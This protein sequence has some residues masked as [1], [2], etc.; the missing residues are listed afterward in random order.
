M[1]EPLR[2]GFAG[3]RDIS[4]HVLNYLIDC[5][6]VPSVLILSEPGTATSA[7]E[8]VEAARRDG[9]VPALLTADDIRGPGAA[10]KIAGY[11]LDY[12][13]CVHFPY[14]LSPRVLS[15]LR[16]GA[17]NLHPAYLPFN[18]GWHTPSWSIYDG[19]PAGATLHFMSDRTDAGD[20]IYQEQ[21][22]VEPFDTAHT[23]YQ[24]LKQKELAV[25]KKGWTDLKAGTAA[26]VPQD[27]SR[28]TTHLK[29][30]LFQEK[31]QRLDLGAEV[32]A[33][34]L[35]KRLR[36]MTTNRQDEAAY[37]ELAGRRYRVQVVINPDAD[38]V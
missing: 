2:L 17:L 19:T 7:G 28:A 27:E 20:I 1:H 21:V 35:L 32:V 33:G 24:K 37:F 36:A 23:L 18:R 26:R 4:V 3:D 22:A 25:F 9:R 38:D 11:E 34:D 30:D 8:L 5:G 10:A 15:A 16:F 12:L 31:Y 13:L 6:D 29:T 14:Y